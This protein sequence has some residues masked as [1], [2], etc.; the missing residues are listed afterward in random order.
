[1]SE[2]C[3]TVSVSK[4]EHGYSVVLDLPHGI[5]YGTIKG[6]TG[7]LADHFAGTGIVRVVAERVGGK[8]MRLLCLTDPSYRPESALADDLGL[9]DADG[10]PHNVR[11]IKGPDGEVTALEIDALGLSD[12]TIRGNFGRWAATLRLPNEYGFRLD[13]GNDQAHRI[14]TVVP[15]PPPLPDRLPALPSGD[16]EEGL[17]IGQ[18]EGKP[19]DTE[20]MYMRFKPDVNPH[21]LVAGSPNSGKSVL[22]RRIVW[23]WLEAG[24]A[25]LGCDPTKGTGFR[26][27]DDYAQFRRV[28][29]VDAIVDA[30]QQAEAEMR[31]RYAEMQQ[32]PPGWEQPWPRVL[33]W[34]EEAGSLLVAPTGKDEESKELAAL[35]AKAK[36]HIYQ[37]IA[38]AR[39]CRITVFLAPQRPSVQIIDGDTRDLIGLRVLMLRQARDQMCQM[40]IE[41]GLDSVI[42]G[43]EPPRRLRQLDSPAGRMVAI[44]PDGN[45]W[46]IGQVA[47]TPMEKV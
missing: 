15:P 32:H 3:R 37:L 27:F 36:R 5:L 17:I 20:P 9:V 30:L 11:A 21:G 12:E 10:Q 19:G 43:D 23:A 24:G 22:A 31:R 42:P 28:V 47:P 6:L 29:S 18:R 45:N 33:I 40:V 26:G 7:D 38:V 16:F 34:I 25:V 8:R 1:M 35:V 44:G 41:S 46:I 39:E 4:F 2:S 13:L 14:V